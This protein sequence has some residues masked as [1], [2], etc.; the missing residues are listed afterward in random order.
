MRTWPQK[1]LLVLVGLAA[2]AW[3]AG[4]GSDGHR[5]TVSAKPH[6]A[7]SVRV[8]SPKSASKVSGDRVAVLTRFSGLLM[9]D[10]FGRAPAPGVGHLQFSL[11]GGKYD[12]RQYSGAAG[13][14]A[15]RYGVAG[16]Y[17]LALGPGLTY[18]RIPNGR[19]TLRV[20]LAGNDL[21]P[22]GRSATVRFTVRASKARPPQPKQ[23]TPP[24]GA[25]PQGSTPPAPVQ[26][27]R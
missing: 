21:K 15:K 10:Q 22:V 1:T 27:P 17:S 24:A 7:P 19:H 26:P 23:P 18:R 2:V 14:L 6:G 16:K 4:C 25:V 3:S 12:F 9:A 8:L 13:K 5:S 11:D 20:T